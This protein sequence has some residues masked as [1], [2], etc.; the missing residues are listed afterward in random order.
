MNTLSDNTRGAIL[1]MV[2]MAAFTFGD[3]C[4]KVASTTL[5]LSQ[6]LVLRGFFASIVIFLIARRMGALRFDLPARDWRLI[7]LRSLAEVGAA[8][9]FLTALFNMPI[10][11]VNALLQMMPL[12]VTLA[13][14][15]F[16]KEP[17]GWR[18]WV[19]IAI[20]F[21]GMLLIV[22]PGTEGFNEY[23]VFALI[24]VVCVTVRDLATRRMSKD[25]PSLTVTLSA[26]VVVLVFA[27]FL[28]LSED[29]QPLDTGLWLLV[30]AMSV[31]IIAGYL[32]SVLAMRTGEVSVVSPFR[33][34]GLIWALVLGWLV[35]GEWPVP[36]TFLGA[37]III[38]TGIFTLLREAQIRRSQ[39]KMRRI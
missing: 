30:G 38:A 3:T 8:W 7:A 10:A 12:T 26:S 13:S 37:G 32:F 4:M 5:P 31:L 39:A 23:S 19:A 6:L 17:V 16:F 22:R 24:S 36:L 2:S 27:G 28:S 18:R 20:G 29:W 1:M 21:C 35:F 25:V 14:A 33:Y 11:N 34:T 9:F 15:I